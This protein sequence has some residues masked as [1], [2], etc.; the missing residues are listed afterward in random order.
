MGKGRSLGAAECERPAGLRSSGVC[1]RRLSCGPEPVQGDVPERPEVPLTWNRGRARW[2]AI[3]ERNSWRPVAEVAPN[4]GIPPARAGEGRLDASMSSHRM[5][6][7]DAPE[8]GGRPSAV[9]R[10]RLS[11]GPWSRGKAGCMGCPPCPTDCAY[12]NQRGRLCIGRAG[13]NDGAWEDSGENT[14]RPRRLSS[15]PRTRRASR[16]MVPSRGHSSPRSQNC[17]SPTSCTCPISPRRPLSPQRRRRRLTLSPEQRSLWHDTTA[18]RLGAWPMRAS[19]YARR[20]TDEHQAASLDVQIGKA[21]ALDAA[22][23]WSIEDRHL[24]VDDAVSRAEFKKRPGWRSR[25]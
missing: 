3:A 7:A 19:I 13:G 23:G 15:S 1:L 2:G 6:G 16:A 21:K 20:S 17:S 4:P 24:F 22:K 10:R 5:S 12:S 8:V 9:G 14:A 11:R 18:Q 25:S